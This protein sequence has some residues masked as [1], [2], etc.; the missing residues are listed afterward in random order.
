MSQRNALRP[1]EFSM[2]SV[3]PKGAYA[4]PCPLSLLTCPVPQ[5]L[6]RPLNILRDALGII[7]CLNCLYSQS[8]NGLALQYQNKNIII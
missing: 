2:L 3:V 8:T 7:N 6:L 1:K 5:S 4:S